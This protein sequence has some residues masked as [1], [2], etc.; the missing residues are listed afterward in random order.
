MDRN[1][2]IELCNVNAEENQVFLKPVQHQPRITPAGSGRSAHF[3]LP[4]SSPHATCFGTLRANLSE[5]PQKP[6]PGSSQLPSSCSPGSCHPAS[7]AT[8]NPLVGPSEPRHLP[9]SPAFVAAAFI[10]CCNARHPRGPQTAGSCCRERPF[11]L[12]VLLAHS[13]NTQL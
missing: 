12:L 1:S 8:R 5:S 4:H 9:E 6:R 10:P 2:N 13:Q 3:L 7:A 11:L